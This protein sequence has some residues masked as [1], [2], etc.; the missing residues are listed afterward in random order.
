MTKSRIIKLIA[1]ITILV[2]LI[3]LTGLL[4]PRSLDEAVWRYR[5]E[6]KHVTILRYDRVRISGLSCAVR[7]RRI[8]IRRLKG[9]KVRQRSISRSRIRI[10]DLQIA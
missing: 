2:L 6:P 1:V 10:S 3:L 8:R 9:E 5:T 7:H 4:L